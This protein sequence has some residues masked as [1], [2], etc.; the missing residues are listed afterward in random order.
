MPSATAAFVRRLEYMLRASAPER[1]P[2]LRCAAH[3][4]GV[5]ATPLRLIGLEA[6]R[7]NSSEA[8]QRVVKLDVL[9]QARNPCDGGSVRSAAAGHPVALPR[10]RARDMAGAADRA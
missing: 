8:E 10:A 1:S 6:P 4:R 5:V 2:T 3:R 7:M 9:R